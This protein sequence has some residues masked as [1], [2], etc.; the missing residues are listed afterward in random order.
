M[1]LLAS[2]PVSASVFNGFVMLGYVQT[3]TR[4]AVVQE[5]AALV[6]SKV[7]THVSI[8]QYAAEQ[9]RMEY[10]LGQLQ[11]DDLGRYE[12]IPVTLLQQS[13]TKLTQVV[14][15]ARVAGGCEVGW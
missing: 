10:A 14:R 4:L 1:D 3:T 2:R 6:A 11:F 8:T 5:A 9:M 12:Y 7:A 13:P 15:E